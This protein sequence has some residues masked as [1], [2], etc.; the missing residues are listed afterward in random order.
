MQKLLWLAVALCCTNIA[1]RGADQFDVL[2]RNGTIY[3]GNG[4]KPFT[5]D[6]GINGDKIA[7][8]GDL[9]KARGKTEVN[10]KGLAVAPGFINMLSWANESLIAD[11]RSQGDIRQGVTLEVMG[12][13]SSMGPLGDAMKKESAEQQGDI[14]YP[15]EWTTLGQYLDYLTKRGISCNVAS[16]IGATTV[17]VH[18]IGYAD[19][20][21]TSEEL[22]RMKGLVRQAMEE[23]ALGVGSSLIYAPAFY[24]KTDELIALCKVAAEYD[25][26][27]IS[28]IRSE[29]SRLLEAADELI[30]IARDAGIRAEFYHLKA[31]GKPNWNKLDALCKKIENARTQGLHITA[32][33]YTYVAAGTGLD[34]TMP[35][36]VQEGG[37]KEWVKRLQDPAIR[38]RV[39]QEM[40]TPTDKWENFFVAAGSPDRILLVG[41]KTEKLKPLIGKTLAEVAKLRGTS[42]E[43]TA[44]DLVIEDNGRVDTIYFLMDEANVRKQIALPWVSFGSDEG[45]YSPEGVFLKSNPHPRAYGNFARLLGKYVR[46][47]KIISLEEAVR[48]L[49]SLPADNLKLD[50]RG[51]L[52]S[53]NFA[54]IVIFDPKTIQDRATFEK[55]HQFATGMRDVFVNGVQVLKDGDHTGAKPGQVVRGP[56]WKRKQATV[57]PLPRLH[58][59][60]DYQHARPLLDALSHGFCSVEADIHLVDGKLLVAHNRDATKPERTL[61]ALYLDPLRERV[62][63]NGGRVFPNG[64]EFTLLIDLKTNWPVIYPML[65]AVLT[66]YS[67]MLSTFRDGEKQ[68]NAVTIIITGDRSPDMFTDES[69]RYAAYDG[70]LSDLD[71]TKPAQSI[72]W[73][74]I[75]WK[76]QFKW[77][78]SG[79]MPADE[80]RRL[81]EIVAKTHAHGRQLRFWGAPDNPKSWQA[82]LDAGVD[83]INTDD[84]A[85]AE[86]FLRT[87]QPNTSQ[88]SPAHQKQFRLSKAEY[89]DRL[90]AIWTSQIIACLMGF[91]FEHKVASTKWVESYP[92][93]PKFAPVDDDWYYEMCAIRAF[94]KHGIALTVEQLGEQWKENSCGSWGSSE[95]ARLLLMRGIKAPDTGHPRYNKFWFSIGPQFS[96]D[97]YGAL[98][99]GM[100]NLAGKL[101]REYGHVNGYAEAVDG[102]VFMAGMVSLGFIEADTKAI[103]RKAAQLIHPSSPYRQCLDMVIAMAESGKSPQEIAQAVEDRWHIE[104]PWT[105]NAVPNGGLA[106]IAVWF[107]EGDF[108]K[109]VNIVY[110]AADFTDADCNAAN[111]AAV[112]AAMHGMK[113]LPQNLVEPLHDRI[114]GNELG[115]VKLTPPVDEK[116][117]E[118]ARRTA[119]IGEQFLIANSARING[120]EIFIAAQE[121]VTQAAELFSLA[122]LTKFWNSDWQLERVGFGGT[123]GGRDNL[124]GI[125]C[126]DGDV[127]ATWPRDPVRG[128]VLRRDVKLSNKPSLALQVAADATRMWGLEIYADNQRVFQK[129]ID[130]GAENSERK[131]QDIK[132]DLTAFANQE[133]A[134][135][136]YQRV[137]VGNRTAGTA[138]WKG[139]SLN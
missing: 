81:A 117:S 115:N 37:L 95:Q 68:T 82:T 134:L 61:Q 49:T 136:L 13:G 70:K 94:E 91:Q 93:T 60:N 38:A 71:S 19:R 21:P 121:P 26:M 15:I 24:A 110:R 118:L 39:K 80:K 14:K 112:V 36:W 56:G 130:G 42:P 138:Y 78:G 66:N 103:V 58:A 23:G 89:V 100:P 4:G 75:E 41:F 132:V 20:A 54:D 122:D 92:K 12:E 123:V 83:L 62:R 135:R 74:S 64:P 50:R 7:A 55:P 1:A 29:G 79:S 129:F 106:A 47:D 109:T 57:S 108:L 53:G 102:A 133:V 40:A 31:A 125:T 127:L 139:I 27:Y 105:N 69:V 90:Q 116:I 114:V 131:W 84:L 22:E 128:V 34:A 72:P 99:P 59:H 86:K 77:S 73:I 96:A 30:T 17:R 51:T 46:E 35:P 28:H 45:S 98:A 6:I 5:G 126:L 113:S 11:G 120:D 10:A 18:E 63:Q 137:M 104:Y 85:G 67:E 76:K 3:D 107:G 43:E 124:R 44:M 52:K 88:L 87:K 101:A 111:A 8:I 32:D 48:R 9:K 2:I 33:M 25:G 65:S 97:V 119:K 16:F